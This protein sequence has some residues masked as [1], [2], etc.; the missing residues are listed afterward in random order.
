MLFLNSVNI[1]KRKK[2][3]SAAKTNRYFGCTRHSG[4]IPP[5]SCVQYRPRCGL[6][7]QLICG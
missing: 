6:G 7:A 2:K 4:T 3:V 1:Q 5:C